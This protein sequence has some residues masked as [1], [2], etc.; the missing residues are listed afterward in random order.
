M[1]LSSVS[2]PALMPFSSVMLL[3]SLHLKHFASFPRHDADASK[4]KGL[5]TCLPPIS[6]VI[7][8]ILDDEAA[9]RARFRRD[10]EMEAWARH[11]RRP[12]P[13]S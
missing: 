3:S 12:A 8:L 9:E 11:W 7:P 10:D 4:L 5:F 1:L 2:I 6:R 13:L